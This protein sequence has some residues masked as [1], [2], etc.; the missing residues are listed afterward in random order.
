MQL[1]VFNSYLFNIL[2]WINEY[3]SHQISAKSDSN[4]PSHALHF[5]FMLLEVENI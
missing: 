4:T 1:L 2:E 5:L 3:F